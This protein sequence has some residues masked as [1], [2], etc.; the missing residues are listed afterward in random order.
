MR[1]EVED[2]DISMTV[3]IEAID[4]NGDVRYSVQEKSG[5][6]VRIK[7]FEQFEKPTALF[8]ITPITIRRCTSLL[9]CM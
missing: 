7:R 8:M 1:I 9:P 4:E 3:A 2:S 6:A 5:E